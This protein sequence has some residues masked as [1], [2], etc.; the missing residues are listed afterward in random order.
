MNNFHNIM[1]KMFGGLILAVIAFMLIRFTDAHA[2]TT[3]NRPIGA[4]ANV[5]TAQLC[6]SGYS[7]SVRP[8][9]SYTDGLKRKWVPAGHSVSEYELDHS[10]PIAIGGDPRN[11][12][13]LWLQDWPSAKRKDVL[14]NQLHKDLCSGKIT[15]KQAQDKIQAWK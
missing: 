13:N 1:I 2:A 9:T 6:V 5:T 4:V 11:T 10:I 15:L 14:E 8:P 3:T 12:N 7:A